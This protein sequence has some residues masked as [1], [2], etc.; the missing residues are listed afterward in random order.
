MHSWIQRIQ[1]KV[2]YLFCLGKSK[3]K[4]ANYYRILK[5]THNSKIFFIGRL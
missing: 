3:S 5:L 2:I 4:Q 1:I